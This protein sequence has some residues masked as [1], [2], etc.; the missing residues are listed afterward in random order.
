LNGWNGENVDWALAKKNLLEDLLDNVKIVK[1][2]GVEIDLALTM[3]LDDA[4]KKKRSELSK[5]INTT[6]I[7]T[8]NSWKKIF[9]AVLHPALEALMGSIGD[10]PRYRRYFSEIRNPNM[11]GVIIHA[12]QS[13]SKISVATN[14]EDVMKIFHK[15]GA[16]GFVSF[17]INFLQT[18]KTEVINEICL[19]DQPGEGFNNPETYVPVN[20]RLEDGPADPV[21]AYETDIRHQFVLP[22][23]VRL[24]KLTDG[25]SDDDD[26]EVDDDMFQKMPVAPAENDL[27][28]YVLMRAEFMLRDPEQGAKHPMW[29][30]VDWLF[31]QIKTLHQVNEKQVAPLAMRAL[32]FSISRLMKVNPNPDKETMEIIASIIQAISFMSA[33]GDP[34]PHGCIDTFFNMSP[35][36]VPRTKDMERNPWQIEV[37]NILS[38]AVDYLCPILSEKEYIQIRANF[39]RAAANMVKRQIVQKL[40]EDVREEQKK[41]CKSEE[42]YVAQVN[43]EFY[44]AY[45][46]VVELIG[47]LI[48][49]DPETFELTNEISQR[50][51][52]LY[53]TVVTVWAN[54]MRR[55]R[56]GPVRKL[57]DVLKTFSKKGKEAMKYLVSRKKYLQAL[58]DQVYHIKYESCDHALVEEVC[59]I[60]RVKTRNPKHGKHK[61]WL[62]RVDQAI[63]N[64][65]TYD[66]RMEGFAHGNQYKHLPTKL[67]LKMLGSLKADPISDNAVTFGDVKY[68]LAHINIDVKK[69]KDL[70]TQPIQFRD[71]WWMCQANPFKGKTSAGVDESIPSVALISMNLPNTKMSNSSNVLATLGDTY[72]KFKLARLYSGQ[73]Q[74]MRSFISENYKFHLEWFEETV[75]AAGFPQYFDP[76]LVQGNE[77]IAIYAVVQRLVD[78]LVK[79]ESDR[80]E[81]AREKVYGE[82]Q[83][84]QMNLPSP[85]PERLKL[86]QK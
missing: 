30:Y 7:S 31:H 61:N 4:I 20:H 80:G 25:D 60:I 15:M 49:A 38:R 24:P 34:L 76:N 59:K 42:D 32:G 57:V 77:L 74:P 43:N 84:P 52:I 51:E 9:N 10:N 82:I 16:T 83:A 68:L 63:D 8:L 37:V 33:R 65:S 54:S 79:D 55:C 41:N 56:I 45:R 58:Y 26:S 73:M 23:F 13:T 35:T 36:Y 11:S 48:E 29:R 18:W 39:Q 53:D 86:E 70:K 1:Q 12:S 81:K 62:A 17:T 21:A 27:A 64:I 22:T 78:E 75:R 47:T 69:A 3:K 66:K 28:K 5:K 67:M 19:L 85:H 46:E 14:P 50:I 71:T 72:H 44:P 40:L 6:K 2:E